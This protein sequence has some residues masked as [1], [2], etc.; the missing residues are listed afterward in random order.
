MIILGLVTIILALLG[1]PLF[2]I[3]AA[4]ALLHYYAV[5]ID[6]SVF[7]IEFNRLSTMPMLLPIPLFTFAG[8][9]LAESGTP[10]R[11]LR[12]SRALLG[13]MPGGPAI[14][15]I[16]A[17]ALFTAFTG[18]SGVTIIALGGLLYPALIKEGY[19]ERF[20]LGLITT[21]GSLGLLFPPSLPL[22]IYGVI[23]K[24]SID[25]LFRGGFLP[26]VLMIVLLSFYSAFMSF[27]Q[28]VKRH[29]FSL[30]ELRGAL[31]E[32]R[33]EL[34]LPFIVLGG[35]YSGYIAISEAA[36]ITAFLVIIIEV[37]L[38]REISFRKLPDIMRRSM[39]L[40]GS[41]F[42]IMGCAMAYTNYLIDAEIPMKILDLIRQFI[43][44]RI[45]FLIALNIFLL[46]VGCMLDI[47][48][49]LIVVVPL[50]TPIAASYNIDPVHLGVIFLANLNI[51]YMT[52][53]VGLNLFISSVRFKKP[54]IT[55]YFATLPYLA[56]MLISLIIITYVSYL[57]LVLVP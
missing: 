44:S 19:N 40:V 56:M 24:T 14:V 43:D 16:V 35:I 49:A 20:S 2:V 3:I 28:N 29:K 34:P 23:A 51:G 5:D 33:Y 6:L 37:F 11:M 46:I 9:M 50:I 21:A 53:P 30:V 41:I 4:N 32:S 15:C 48:S 55:L 39:I 45:A 7:A 18:A 26:G 13:W 36:A 1:A 31:W 27:S 17:S 25:N 22:I 38:Y 8:Y 12:L 52:P 47:F 42:I 54:V 57:S 10:N